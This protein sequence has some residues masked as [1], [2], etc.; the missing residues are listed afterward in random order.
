MGGPAKAPYSNSTRPTVSCRVKWPLFERVNLC[1]RQIVVLWRRKKK[2]MQ[3]SGAQGPLL[4][5]RVPVIC[6]GSLY[7]F[8][9]ASHTLSR[10]QFEVY[11]YRFSDVRYPNIFQE[12]VA[13][14]RG[15]ELQ[16]LGIFQSR[17]NSE[18]VSYLSLVVGFISALQ[19]GRL[20]F[21]FPAGA[22]DFYLLQNFQGDSGAP[23]SLL[24]REYHYSFLE[25]KR[26]GSDVDHSPL[27]GTEV[28]NKWSCTS[29]MVS[30][31]EQEPP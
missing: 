2:Y 21:I 30:W 11:L 23:L 8:L 16:S 27:P 10:L 31:S 25:V 28:K 17:Q 6:T 15:K 12:H 5:G 26:S 13:T 20:T 19:S 24:L 3:H 29:Y 18:R 9:S 7:P 22:R 1:D 14:T 4:D